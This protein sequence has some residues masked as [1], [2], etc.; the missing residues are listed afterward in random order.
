MIEYLIP[1]SEVFAAL[2]PVSVLCYAIT[3]ASFNLCYLKKR[4]HSCKHRVASRRAPGRRSPASGCE[5]STVECASSLSEV[6]LPSIAGQQKCSEL[7]CGCRAPGGQ[8]K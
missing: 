1:A 2:K 8:Q 7:P 6:L 3:K 5:L 4:V